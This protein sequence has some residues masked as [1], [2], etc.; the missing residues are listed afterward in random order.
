MWNSD[1]STRAPVRRR[2]GRS[3]VREGSCWR[4]WGR[5]FARF[6]FMRRKYAAEQGGTSWRPPG[7]GPREILSIL[8]V[9]VCDGNYKVISPPDRHR[10]TWPFLSS[11]TRFNS[12]RNFTSR[13]V[14][15]VIYIWTL[16]CLHKLG[17]STCPCFTVKQYEEMGTHGDWN[18]GGRT[19]RCI[20]GRVASLTLP[21]HGPPA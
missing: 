4:V 20:S 17:R 21:Q 10:R 13:F 12:T 14:R 8:V 15:R 7:P 1:A 2:H 19:L 9:Y 18:G 3:I 6:G 16:S 11:T 5:E